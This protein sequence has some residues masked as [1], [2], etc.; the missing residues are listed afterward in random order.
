MRPSAADI[1]YNLSNRG[2][3]ATLQSLDVQDVV[4]SLETTPSLIAHDVMAFP[5]L[6]RVCISDSPA[7][8]RDFLSKLLW[9][10]DPV[11]QM[12]TTLTHD[13]ADEVEGLVQTLGA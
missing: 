12:R 2:G 1:L 4:R 5:A 10:S 11:L 8:T 3:A 9:N 13:G 6:R 7:S